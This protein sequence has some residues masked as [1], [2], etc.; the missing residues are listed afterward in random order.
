[1]HVLFIHTYIPVLFIQTY[2]HVFFIY[3]HPYKSRLFIYVTYIQACTDH[4]ACVYNC[5]KIPT[6]H[7]QHERNGRV[8]RLKIISVHIRPFRVKSNNNL[9]STWHIFTGL[10]ASPIYWLCCMYVTELTSYYIVYGIVITAAHLG[11][12]AVCYALPLR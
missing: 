10:L 1:M 5:A 11:V 7:K 12:F 4:S 2:I 6:I 3:T 8:I 9:C